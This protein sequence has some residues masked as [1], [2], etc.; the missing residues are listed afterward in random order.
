MPVAP[1]CVQLQGTFSLTKSPRLL[2]HVLERDLDLVLLGRVAFASNSKILRR[3]L[4]LRQNTSIVEQ[5][6][7]GFSPGSANRCN[8]FTRHPG[9]TSLPLWPCLSFRYRQGSSHLGW[10]PHVAEPCHR[11]RSRNASG[12]CDGARFGRQL[13]RE[14]GVTGRITPTEVMGGFV[15]PKLPNPL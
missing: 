10:L 13:W 11:M 8:Q 4:Q 3:L 12:R 1:P 14:C 6:C 9:R 15:T 7:A 5:G 2:D